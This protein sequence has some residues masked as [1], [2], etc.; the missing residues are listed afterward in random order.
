VLDEAKRARRLEGQRF[1]DKAGRAERF[2]QRFK[3]QL[4]AARAIEDAETD[5]RKRIDQ[6]VDKGTPAR[7]ELPR[8]QVLGRIPD[9]LCLVLL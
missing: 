6:V 8:P 4:R 7:L 9:E 2:G 1:D 3:R 5:P